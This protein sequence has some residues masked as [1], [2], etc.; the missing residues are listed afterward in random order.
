MADTAFE[1][2]I[3]IDFYYFEVRPD[4]RIPVTL[5]V[6]ERRQTDEIFDLLALAHC[7]GVC[8][9]RSWW[10]WIAEGT[11]YTTHPLACLIY[12]LR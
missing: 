8:S 12:V 10:R 11:L 6:R 7:R 9:R 2:H 5:G 4:P 1:A 3:A